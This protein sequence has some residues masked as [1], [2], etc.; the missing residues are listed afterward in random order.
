MCDNVDALIAKSSEKSICVE[1]CV[2]AFMTIGCPSL[3]TDD[4]VSNILQTEMSLAICSNS[5][6]QDIYDRCSADT[7]LAYHSLSVYC[8]A[9]QEQSCSFSIGRTI[10]V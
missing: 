3:K 4:L 6:D 1:V 7:C 9:D 5:A 8:L 10:G 2:D